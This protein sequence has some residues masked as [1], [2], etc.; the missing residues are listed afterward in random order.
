MNPINFPQVNEIHGP[1]EG[2]TNEEC[3]DLPVC[4][5]HHP[6]LQEVFISC[7]ELTDEDIRL[8]TLTRKLWLWQ[9]GNFVQPICPTADNPFEEQKDG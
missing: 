6:D 1:P 3:M 8:L 2:M 5:V 9:F 4:H 7:W